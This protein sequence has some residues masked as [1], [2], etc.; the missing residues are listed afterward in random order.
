M[1]RGSEAGVR[2]LPCDKC[3]KRHP[4]IGLIRVYSD[5][6][7]AFVH[8]CYLCTTATIDPAPVTC[9]SCGATI[10][11]YV[12]EGRQVWLKI[13]TVKIRHANGICAC[14][15]DWH[16]TSSDRLLERIVEHRRRN[17]DRRETE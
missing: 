15:Q 12:T 9:S 6:K 5:S 8:V 2:Y 11:E 7:K 17:T 3:G 16:W 14:G 4:S 10:G 1:Q 13:G